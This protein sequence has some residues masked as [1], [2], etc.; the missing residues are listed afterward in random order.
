MFAKTTKVG[1]AQRVVATLVAGA[2]LMWS[3]GYYTTAQ[4]ANLTEISDLLSTSEPA[5]VANH[6]ITFT[7]PT[8]VANN[9]TITIDFSDG[10]FVVGSVDFTDIDVATSSGEF[11]L[12]ANCA[13]TE[14]ASAVFA[15][16]TL[17]IT[18][19]A[20]DGG[21][22]AANG[23]TTIE[24]GTHA[25]NQ[26]TGDQQLTNPGLGSWEIVATAGNS[27]DTG[28]TRVAI[29]DT[30]LVTAI[31]DTV[32]DFTITGLATSTAVNGTSTTGS[33]TVTEIPFG[34]LV[35]GQPKSLAQ[36]L[37]VRT[38]ARNGFIVTV[39]SDG[40]LDSATGAIIDNFVDGFDTS[41]TGNAWIPPSNDVNDERTWGHWGFTSN[42]SDLASPFG[43]EE[44]MAASTSPR[45]VFS[46]NGPAD[47]STQDIGQADVLY[48]V[49]ITPLQEAADDYSTILTYVA[50]PTF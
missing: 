12:A 7:T 34:K 29:V 21:L 40:D 37:N 17:T 41:T 44:F 31:V 43:A 50:T 45:Q 1:F 8:G 30:V 38:N 49:Q 39:Q 46:H 16:T 42:D 48:Q 26:T 13:G 22:I 28:R 36:R 32:F 2:M 5:V 3:V 35:A 9:Q 47:F 19:C 27:A 18:M 10:P 24:I 6:T 33:T 11:S 15:G 20:G 14:M 4:A 25:T 23:T